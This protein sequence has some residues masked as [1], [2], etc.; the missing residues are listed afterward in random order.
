MQRFALRGGLRPAA[1]AR[2]LGLEGARWY[3]VGV[4]RDDARVRVEPF[5][6]FELER[7][8]LAK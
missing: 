7:T 2:A 1:N 5:Q 4:R 3:V 6:A 8:A